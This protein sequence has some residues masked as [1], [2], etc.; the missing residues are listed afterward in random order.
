VRGF[1]VRGLRRCDRMLTMPGSE[2]RPEAI[3]AR[4]DHFVTTHW[5][6]VLAAKDGASP[7]A[8]EAMEKL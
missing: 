3:G 7:Q 1:L 6:V 4:A 2:A 8:M 5:T